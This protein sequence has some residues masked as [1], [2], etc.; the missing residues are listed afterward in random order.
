MSNGV[1]LLITLGFLFTDPK[2]PKTFDSIVGELD[3]LESP[4]NSA[5]SNVKILYTV[6]NHEMNTN[7]YLKIHERARKARVHKFQSRPIYEACKVCYLFFR[8][9]GLRRFIQLCERNNK[10]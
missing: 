8:C 4:L 2:E 6:K 7:A 9:K 1:L 3:H 10:A 5:W